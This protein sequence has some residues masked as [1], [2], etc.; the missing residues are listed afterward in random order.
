MKYIFAQKG[1]YSWKTIF[2]RTNIRKSV[3]ENAA[4]F[5]NSVH[6][7]SPFVQFGDVLIIS[8]DIAAC[9]FLVMKFSPISFLM[10]SVV[11]YAFV[12]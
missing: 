4:H 8:F 3:Y 9:S 7:I 10:S 11:I 1:K 2:R 6:V 5:H 12:F